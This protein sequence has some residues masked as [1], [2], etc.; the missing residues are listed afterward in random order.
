[1]R[2]LSLLDCA[3]H[4]IRVIQSKRVHMDGLYIHDRVNGN[5]DGFHFISAE[6]VTVTTARC[7]HR[8]MP[9]RCLEAASS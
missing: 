6:Y 2:N 3:Y 1:M 7:S 4:S 8:T 9:A 5:N